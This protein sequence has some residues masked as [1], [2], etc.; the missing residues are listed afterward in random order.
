M[1]IY[2]N[3]DR[4]GNACSYCRSTD[5]RATECPIAAYDWE[6]WSNHRVPVNSQSWGSWKRYD[7]NAWFKQARKVRGMVEAKQE[8]EAAKKANGGTTRRAA[9]KCGFCG[10]QGHNRRNCESLATLKESF[11]TANQNWRRALYD[12]LVKEMGISVG[13][14]IK[15]N[16][17]RARWNNQDPEPEY[18][19]GLVTAISWNKGSFMTPDTHIDSDYRDDIEITV[20]VNGEKKTLAFYDGIKDSAGRV[21]LPKPRWWGSYMIARFVSVIGPS[22]TPLDEK[23]VTEGMK[24]EFDYLLKKRSFDRLTELR[25][26]GQH[27]KWK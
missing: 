15:V 21:L 11:Y 23:W 10:E 6:E 5:H 16:M 26:I 22:K 18:Q 27:D 3:K 14:A 19:V 12:K 2:Q 24:N 7:Y 9:S 8:R 17:A 20:L 1:R 13:A 4:R 25:I